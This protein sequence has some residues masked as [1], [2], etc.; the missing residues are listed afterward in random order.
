MGEPVV[1]FALGV[2]FFVMIVGAYPFK[3]SATMHDG[4]YS[5]LASG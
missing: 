2:A 3:E 4:L 5:L 1:V